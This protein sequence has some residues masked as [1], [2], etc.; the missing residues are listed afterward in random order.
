MKNKTAIKTINWLVPIFIVGLIIFNSTTEALVLAV[1]YF[2]YRVIIELS[3]IYSYIAIKN[4]SKGNLI[5]ARKYYKKAYEAKVKELPIVASYAYLLILL[6]EYEKA[7]EVLNELEQMKP[8]G[9]SMISLMLCRAVL[10]WKTQKNLILA[11]SKIEAMDETMRNQWYYNV[12]AKLCIFS[13]DVEKAKQA[14][15]KGY[16]YLKTNPVAIE[17]LLIIHCINEDYDKALS[18]AQKLINGK[19]NMKP[20]SRDAYYYCALAYEKNNDTDMAAKLYV[21]ALEY[22][23]TSMTYADNQQVIRKA[24]EYMK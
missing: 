21:K 2:I 13:E 12:Y 7:E 1:A 5:K 23:D 6:R 17:N 3:R 16:E 18:A 9:K 22:E 24:G 8:E 14:A 10:A 15:I 11:L 20:S 19:K 4:Y